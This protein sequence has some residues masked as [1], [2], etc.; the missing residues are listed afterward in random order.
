MTSKLGCQMVCFQTRNPNL[1]KFWRA[2]EWMILVYFM[3]I[4]G[5]FGICCGHFVKFY[6]YLVYFSRLGMLYQEKYANPASK[7]LEDMTRLIELKCCH[8]NEDPN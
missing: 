5:P 7:M 8:P 2:L 3:S 6:G 4:F 1:G